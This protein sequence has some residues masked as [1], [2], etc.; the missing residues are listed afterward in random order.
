[1]YLQL[2]EIIISPFL[3]F[4]DL[5]GTRVDGTYLISQFPVLA[6]E[7]SRDSKKVQDILPTMP[8]G[9]NLLWQGRANEVWDGN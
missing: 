6:K 4:F 1:M 8:R 5:A 9:V 2:A 3:P 7:E